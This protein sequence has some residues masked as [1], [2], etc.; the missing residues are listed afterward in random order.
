MTFCSAIGSPLDMLLV[1]CRGLLGSLPIA[2][3]LQVGVV[4]EPAYLV[5]AMEVLVIMLQAFVGAFVSEEAVT[6]GQT[7]PQRQLTGVTP[8][9]LPPES[10]LQPNPSAS[11]ADSDVLTP[12]DVVHKNEKNGK[13]PKSPSDKEFGDGLTPCCILSVAPPWG[14][15]SA[16]GGGL[17]GAGDVPVYLVT[18]LA[19]LG[20]VLRSLMPAPIL[21]IDTET[22]G[23]DPHTARI[24]LIQI[25]APG[26]PVALLDMWALPAESWDSIR[27]LLQKPGIKIFQNAKFD[28]QIFLQ[29]GIALGGTLFDTMI[30]SQLVYGGLKKP[31][32]L[33]ALALEHLG[34]NLSKQ[35]QKSNWAGDLTLAQLEYAA[36]DALVLLHLRD[37]LREKL[38]SAG[39]VEVAKL[40]FD[41]LRAIALM[42]FNGMLLDRERWEI[43]QVNAQSEFDA[44]IAQLKH[45]GI[46]T[47]KVNLNSADQVKTALRQLG[48]KVSSTDKNTLVSLADQHPVVR[49]LLE[50]RRVSKL[51]SAFTDTYLKHINPATGRIHASYMQLGCRTGRMSAN[52]PNLQQVPRDVA[53]RSCFRAALGHKIISADYSQIELRLV[54]EIAQDFRMIAAYRNGDDLHKLTAALIANKPLDS[55]TSSER[56]AAKAINFGLIYGCGAPTLRRTAKSK[57]DVDLTLEEAKAYRNQYFSHYKGIHIWH[58]RL[59]RADFARRLEIRTRSNRRRLWVERPRVTATSNS[60]VQGTAADILKKALALLPAAIAHTGAKIIGAVHDEILLECPSDTAE[61]AAKILRSTMIQAGLAFMKQVPIE[62]DIA[63]GD[64]WDKG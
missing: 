57:Y 15:R 1:V 36:M 40:E 58:M 38:V 24:R 11:K 37:V 41:A 20:R 46:D 45:L 30:A 55:V 51:R 35:C 2:A 9:G 19:V 14:K 6:S 52:N 62:V 56:T 49:A 42:E 26:L 7:A 3:M 8:K 47:L 34:L 59:M 44:A 43:L 54:A 5:A 63:I 25:A 31:H 23:L 12:A 60:I 29:R 4:A 64:S 10:V 28:C 32:S 17:R 21:A 22:T 61:E 33:A 16:E 18:D 50:Y 39:L 27:E 13:S 48:V 53:V